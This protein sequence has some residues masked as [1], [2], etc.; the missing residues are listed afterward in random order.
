M[1]SDMRGQPTP[2][3]FAALAL[4]AAGAIGIL[5]SGLGAA[6]ASQAQDTPDIA[7]PPVEE[8][9]LS[10]AP[11]AA[12]AMVDVFSGRVHTRAAVDSPSTGTVDSWLATPAKAPLTTA[13]I[14]RLALPAV[15]QVVTYDAARKSLRRGS[16][17]IVASEGLIVTSH[18]VLRGARSVEVISSS[19]EVYDVVSVAGEDLR[20]DLAVL[21]VAGFE[22]PTVELGA[23]QQVELGEPVTVIGSPL[24]LANTVSNG[25]VSAKRDMEGSQILQITAPISTGSSGGPVFDSRGRVIGVL[26]GYYPRGQNVNF[27]VP[28]EYARGLLE[29][30]ERS[31]SVTSVGQKRSMLLGDKE[32]RQRDLSLEAVLRGDAIDGEEET[33]W[34]LQPRRIDLERVKA[35]PV[36]GPS[37]LVGLWE[38]RELSRVPGTKSAVYRGVWASDAVILEGS[39]YGALV[40]GTDYDLEFAPKWLRSFEGEIGPDGRA[41]LRGEQGCSYYVHASA[42]AMVGV[43]ECV[44]DRGRVYDLGAVEVVRIDG[45]G[46]TGIYRYSETGKRLSGHPATGGTAILFGLPDGRWTGMLM[47]DLEGLVRVYPLVDGRWTGDGHLSARLNAKVGPKASGT[48]AADAVQL[49]YP[50][51]GSDYADLIKLDAVREP[52]SS[53]PAESGPDDTRE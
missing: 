11:G 47:Q 42:D 26:A 23:M 25:I 33:A 51:G 27:A 14:A 22:L 16:G 46:P 29:I 50:V 8:P 44:D 4:A 36:K 5:P 35:N 40:S 34:A 31:L 7:P 38:I 20:R 1:Q 41:T 21:R 15:V 52:R 45:D 2:G 49:L 43:Y 13:Q 19:G 6:S 28:I 3:R 30:P 12:G 24:G 48:F 10:L 39:F 18:H 17:F 53:G 37:E 9:A 32:R